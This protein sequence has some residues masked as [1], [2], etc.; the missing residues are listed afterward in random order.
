[1]KASRA[2]RLLLAAL[3]VG[4]L[5]ARS[6]TMVHALPIVV[7][8]FAVDPTG[9][10]FS[11]NPIDPG[12]GLSNNLASA[13]TLSYAVTDTDSSPD[14]LNTMQ[15]NWTPFDVGLPAQAGW[16]LVFGA[17][18]DIR[19]QTLTLSINP[20]GL[21]S[22]A[23]ASILQLEILVRDASGKSAGIW[24]FNTDQNGLIVLGND[25]LTTSKAPVAAAPIIPGPLASLANSVMQTVTI[26]LGTGPVPNSA[27]VSDGF[28]TRTGPNYLFGPDV[29]SLGLEFAASLEFYENGTLAG[30]LALPATAAAG[31]NN[32]WDHITLTPEPSSISLAA[33]ALAGLFFCGWRRRLRG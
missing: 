30:S 33:L 8:D 6:A 20:P 18:P 3:F 31:L 25:P 12:V 10:E 14:V 23:G 22:P 29:G 32:Y 19:N 11:I 4:G 26:N 28:T 17:D 15:M 13:P 2:F 21:G 9:P 5:L 27:T 24:G 7:N 16:E 1:M